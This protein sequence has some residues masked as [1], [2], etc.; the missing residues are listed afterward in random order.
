[1]VCVAL[2]TSCPDVS[3]RRV[4]PGDDLPWILLMFFAAAKILGFFALPSNDMLVAGLIGLALMRTNAVRA[5]RALAAAALL[6]LFAFG[7]L[8]FGNFLTV[9]LEERF[10]PFDP[11]SGA[12][13]GIVVLGGAIDPEFAGRPH[14]ELNEAAERVTVVAELARRFPAAKILYSG[15]NGRL[16]PEGGSEAHLAAPLLQVFGIAADRLILEEKSR[17]THENAVFSRQVAMPKP[18]ERWLLVTSAWHM[19]RAVGAFRKAGFAVEAYPV[20]YRTRGAS[21][22]WIPFDSVTAGLRRTD[23]ATREWVGLFT[24]WLTGRSSALFPAP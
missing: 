23:V 20:D 21:A 12:P 10:P 4:K 2:K 15:G 19:P 9:P 17:N 14:S 5:G 1:M 8:P 11:A 16:L 7:L 6:L 22:L 18:G 24:Y 13:D 3:V